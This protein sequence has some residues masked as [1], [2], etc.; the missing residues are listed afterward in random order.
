MMLFYYKNIDHVFEHVE[1]NEKVKQTKIV[2]E[3][4]NNYNHDL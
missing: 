1:I 4:S 2:H 3:I